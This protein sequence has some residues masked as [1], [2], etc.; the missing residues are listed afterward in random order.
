MSK[1]KFQIKNLKTWMGRDCPAFQVT[2]WVNG[3]RSFLYTCDGS[4]A[5][6]RVE[7]LD[8]RGRGT[9]SGP[10]HLFQTG[11]GDTQTCGLGRDYPT[12]SKGLNALIDHLRTLPP[13]E[14]PVTIS[15]FVCGLVDTYENDKWLKRNC[16]TKTLFRTPEMPDGEYRQILRKFDQPTVDHLRREFGDTVEIINERFA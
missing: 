6:D 1:A 13:D 14:V 4:G 16:R 8:I 2:V 11:N 7:A 12:G 10:C 3:K 9:A 5:S 15:S